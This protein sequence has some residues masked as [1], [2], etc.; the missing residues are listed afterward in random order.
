MKLFKYIIIAFFCTTLSFAQEEHRA[1]PK[2]NEA[3]IILNNHIVDK[4]I[5]N[6]IDPKNIESVTVWKSDK[7][8]ALYGSQG[9][10]GVLDIT[11]KNISKKE[12]RKLYRE[13][14]PEKVKQIGSGTIAISGIVNNS[15]G[16][17]ITG[18]Y[19]V[20]M[21]TKV[22]TQS[23]F[24][25]KFLITAKKED[26]LEVS[27]VQFKTQK[28]K[29][30]N[31]EKLL[32]KLKE[33][34]QIQLEKP[35]IYLY[36][37]EKTAIE[38]QL[39]LK[40]KLHTTFPKYDSNWKI[41]AEPNGQLFDVKTK[42]YYNSLFW[43][44][45]IDFQE[46]HYK[47]EDGFVV[48]KD[49]L[50]NFLIEK[51]EHIGL[52]NQ[53]TNDFV[54]YWLPVLERNKY[55][56][57]HFTVNEKCDQIAT[58]NVNPNPDTSIRVYME[59][60]GLENF[61]KIKEQEL[62]KTE[63]KGFTLIEWGGADFTGE[64]EEE[65]FFSINNLPKYITFIHRRKDNED[66]KPLYIIDNKISSKKTFDKLHPSEIKKIETYNNKIGTAYY[67]QQ[68]ADGVFVITTKNYKE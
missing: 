21:N 67:G 66:I 27:F 18:A 50:T 46:S 2:D 47:Y 20:N 9:K 54:Q 35:V 39:N 23:D 59:F 17:P 25:G 57:I 29:I 41:I 15:E 58:L 12:L 34:Q 43:D 24:D 7:A 65:N 8:T 10:N 36:P 38:L 61:T 30:I 4:A 37:T 16:L 33:T 56:F 44:G 32:I 22:S 31:Q 60:Y 40:G 53:E 64:M 5:L 3:L 6:S 49:Q 14:D 63:R 48:S 42:R 68:G 11:T 52:N 45:S 55:N 19:V 13:F 1:I 28:I 62:P 26:V 51:L